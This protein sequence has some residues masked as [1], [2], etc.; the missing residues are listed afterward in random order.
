MKIISSPPPSPPPSNDSSLA[1]ATQAR[2]E[3]QDLDALQDDAVQLSEVA[4]LT[5]S[6][7]T[8]T[9]D[10]EKVAALRQAITAGT[11]KIDAE[12]IYTGLVADARE[13]ID[14]EPT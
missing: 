13:M 5:E 2:V 4:T 6:D 12:T 14:I 3:P 8:A 10:L 7:D 11:F 1:G 9:V